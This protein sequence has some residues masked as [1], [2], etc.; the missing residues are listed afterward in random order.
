MNEHIHVTVTLSASPIFGTSRVDYRQDEQQLQSKFLM[1]LLSSVK[2]SPGYYPET[3]FEAVTAA[4]VSENFRHPDNR[5][6]DG[7]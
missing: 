4:K 3:R 1:V 5:D 2:R 6:K 7:L